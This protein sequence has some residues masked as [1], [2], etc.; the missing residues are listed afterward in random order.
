MENLIVPALCTLVAPSTSVS[1]SRQADHSVATVPFSFIIGI[2]RL[3]A[4][5]YTISQAWNKTILAQRDERDAAIR[6]RESAERESQRGKL[7]FQRYGSEYFLHA[8]LS[9]SGCFHISLPTSKAEQK[10]R[11][12]SAAIGQGEP[13]CIAT[14]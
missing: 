5:A 4:G 14:N 8:I 10:V 9:S 11:A 3:P 7:I 13:V 2:T 12:Q 6:G 1:M